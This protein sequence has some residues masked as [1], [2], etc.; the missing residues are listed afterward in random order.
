[1]MKGGWRRT[2]KHKRGSNSEVAMKKMP[3][4]RIDNEGKSESNPL[5]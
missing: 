1:M 2:R 5:F 4:K 3:M